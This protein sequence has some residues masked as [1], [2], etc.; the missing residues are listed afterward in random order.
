[1]FFFGQVFQPNPSTY[2]SSLLSSQHIPF[3]HSDNFLVSNAKHEGSRFVVFCSLLLGSKY[4]LTT[5]FVN[6]SA[7][8]ISSIWN[9]NFDAHIKQQVKC[10]SKYSYFEIAK[11]RHCMEWKV[12]R[13]SWVHPTLNFFMN[14]TLILS[15]S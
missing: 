9:S 11:G 7:Y 1:M 8:V 14:A 5:P 13:I 3:S 6:T 2:L 12:A 10:S 4:L 15:L